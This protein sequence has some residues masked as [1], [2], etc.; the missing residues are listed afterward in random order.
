MNFDALDWRRLD[1]LRGLFLGGEFGGGAYWQDTADLAL[2]DATL[3]ERIGWKWDAV[4][5]ELARRNWAPPPGCELWDWGCGSGVASRRVLAQWPEMFTRL[6]LTDHSS[7]ATEFATQRALESRP[8]FPVQTGPRPEDATAPYVLCVSHVWNELDP[9]V[10][11]ALCRVAAQAAAVIWVE[12]GTHSVARSLQAIRTDL[13]TVAGHQVIAPCTHQAACGLL[14]TGNERHWCHHF[15]NPPPDIFADSDW[16]RFGQRAGVDLRSLPYAFLVTEANPRP[17][18][19]AEPSDLQRVLGSPRVYK[20]YSRV[21]FC[22]AGGVVELEVQQRT[23][24]AVYKA[25][26]KERGG[27]FYQVTAE[28]KRPERAAKIAAW[29]PSPE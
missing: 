13:V 27:D 29:P 19:S 28:S 21:Q 11:A 3:G 25:W 2:Y 10:G 9:L 18:S 6:R 5:R 24:P 26:A 7:L 8:G 14:T 15:A 12:S 4:L 1:R 22:G 23:S 20:G 16:V 17:R